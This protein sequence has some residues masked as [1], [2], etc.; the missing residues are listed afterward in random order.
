MT[1]LRRRAARGRKR[2][3]AVTTVRASVKGKIMSKVSER[4]KLQR[5]IGSLVDEL[6]KLRT[7]LDQ[8]DPKLASTR[9]DI[10]F[11]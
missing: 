2:L 10:L 11:P 4:E 6:S 3:A 1:Q 8:L 5:D 7:K 9:G